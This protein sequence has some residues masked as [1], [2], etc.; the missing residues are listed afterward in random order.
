VIDDV[1]RHGRRLDDYAQNPLASPATLNAEQV[2]CVIG[3]LGRGDI[4]GRDF[5]RNKKRGCFAQMLSMDMHGLSEDVLSE[6][7]EIGF[8]AVVSKS[9]EEN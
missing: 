1:R 2:R 9:R 4:S 6:I 3:M 8:D 7:C 5:E